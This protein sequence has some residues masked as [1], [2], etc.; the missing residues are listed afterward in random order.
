MSVGEPI[1]AGERLIPYRPGLDGLRGLSVAAVLAFHGGFS[2]AVGGYLGVSVFFTL[3]G[4]LITS[5]LLA[6]HDRKGH[7]ALRH[8][9]GRRFRRLLPASLLAL[10]GIGVFGLT[11]ATA[12]QAER[13]G[14]DIAA[15][16][17]Y[18]ANWRF[19][20]GGTSY[21]DLFAEPTPVLHFWSLAIE[22][23]FYLVYPLF[24][25][26]LL[27]LAKGRRLVVGGVLGALLVASVGASFMLGTGNL[28]RI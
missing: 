2:W 6:E 19:I 14:G 3:S 25:V 21:G 28:D 24:M 5:L 13:L 8:F 12:E 18:V 17:A 9:W 20:F 1:Q 11:V 7:V 27:G 10:V 15:A 4:F 16:V 23:Q 22:E 26:G